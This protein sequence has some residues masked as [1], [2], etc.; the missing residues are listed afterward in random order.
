MYIMLVEL[1]EIIANISVV[2]KICRQFEQKNSDR[3]RRK[4]FNGKFKKKKDE[5]SE[6]RGS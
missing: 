6:K 1:F 2:R 3:L 5:K 4:K